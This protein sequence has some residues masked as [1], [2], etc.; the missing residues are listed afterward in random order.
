MNVIHERA[1][2]VSSASTTSISNRHLIKASSGGAVGGINL[3]TKNLTNKHK[4]ASF[5]DH[6]RSTQA[7]GIGKS[8]LEH[9]VFVFPENVRKMLAGSKK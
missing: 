4:T 2:L 3:A 8:V 9:L 1:T 7:R 6:Q 5:D